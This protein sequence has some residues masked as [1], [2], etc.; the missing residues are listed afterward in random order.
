VRR[1]LA[2]VAIGGL[3]LA[4]L[5]LPA[6][7][8]VAPTL[9]IF[10]WRTL[11]TGGC[12]NPGDNFDLVIGGATNQAT[13]SVVM[14]SPTG[15]AI[16]KGSATSS[17]GGWQT[18]LTWSYAATGT[19]ELRASAGGLNV[20]GFLEVPCQ[21][22]TLEFAPTCFAAGY[23][24]TVTMT[25]RHFAP[26][27]S[28]YTVT[29]DLGGSEQQQA[30][31]QVG[32]NHG[33]VNTTFKV[34]PSNRGHPSEISDGNRA[35]VASGTWSPCP[36]GT[37]TT[38]TSSTTTSTTEPESTTTPTTAPP[39]TTTTRPPLPGPDVTVPPSVQL[40]PPTPG[41]TL[42]V[43]PKVGRSGFVTSAVGTGF[44]PNA[45]VVLHWQP[46]VGET[47]AT[48]GADGTFH[49]QV[50]IFP[51]DQLG[52]RALVA[53]SGATTA[54]DAFLVVP[55]TVKPSGQ[56]VAQITRVRRFLQR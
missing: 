29:Y 27:G 55:S 10:T 14:Y 8:Q 16:N 5:V 2:L 41:A 39:S 22:P 4:V 45:P 34:T 26:F 11:R 56:N 31:R 15:A 23:S 24:G 17:G 12:A 30:I 1:L 54:Y 50:L 53:N 21:P 6:A 42:T 47:T 20:S 46:G 49:A 40:P 19:Y 3:A 32:D 44:P 37:T 13:V 25:G 35:L 51:H 7:A 43:T 33:V 38:T 18:S 36:P 28:P 9:S 48:S 52:P